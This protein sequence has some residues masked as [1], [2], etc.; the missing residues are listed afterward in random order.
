LGGLFAGTELGFGRVVADELLDARVTIAAGCIEPDSSFAFRSI[1]VAFRLALR[2]CRACR[3]V[4]LEWGALSRAHGIALRVAVAFSAFG[5]CAY[6]GEIVSG[7]GIAIF[8]VILQR[9]EQC[10]ALFDCVYEPKPIASFFVD[11]L[12]ASVGASAIES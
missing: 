11:R 12:D 7:V 1:A 6:D 4:G 9:R 3:P 8:A 5:R 10:P 2:A